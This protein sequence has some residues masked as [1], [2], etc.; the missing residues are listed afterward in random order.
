MTKAKKTETDSQNAGLQHRDPTHARMH[1]HAYTQK[2]MYIYKHTFAHTHMHT[3]IH[4][5]L[6]TCR[7][8][9]AHTY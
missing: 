9:H 2:Y 1:I 6:H 4:M 5:Y 3:H 8:T 7:C